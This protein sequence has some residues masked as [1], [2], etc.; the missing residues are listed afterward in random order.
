MVVSSLNANAYH[1]LNTEI[2]KFNNAPGKF[3]RSISYDEGY[4]TRNRLGKNWHAFDVDLESI[5]GKF[6]IPSSDIYEVKIANPFAK[7]NPV[8]HTF[9][10]RNKAYVSCRSLL[11]SL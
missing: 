5:F 1:Y 3:D 10:T 6:T 4:D 2:Y 11:L 9:L 8:N 7:S